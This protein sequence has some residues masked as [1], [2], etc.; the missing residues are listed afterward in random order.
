MTTVPRLTLPDLRGKRAVVTGA[1]DGIGLVI[2]RHLAAAGCELVLPVRNLEKGSAAVET[3]LA[4]APQ[5]VVSTAHMD[6]T[7]LASVT[8]FAERLSADGE[9]IH[10]L[11]NNAGVMSP[12]SRQVTEDGFE[13]QFGANHLGHFALVQRL[14]P[15]LRAGKARVTSQTSFD[16]Q[17]ASINWDDI[18]S[19][20]KYSPEAA[21]GQSKLALMLFALELDRRS[22][23]EGWGISSNVSHPGI[24]LTNLLAAHPEMGRTRDTGLIRAIRLFS[25]LGILVQKGDGGGLPA[26]Y[27]ATS[28]QAEGGQL[29]GPDGFSNISGE[30]TRLDIYKSA[31]NPVDAARMWELSDELTY[32]SHIN[33]K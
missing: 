29:Y 33:H 13:L 4:A 2:A 17:R 7:S 19:E 11:V 6:L 26:L 8:A 25:R 14:M 32:S 24:A 28:I 3:I 18:Q 10:L 21:Y 30:P 15:A 16:A 12:P 23:V 27:A 1:S 5:A 9:P 22:R 31:E 20:N